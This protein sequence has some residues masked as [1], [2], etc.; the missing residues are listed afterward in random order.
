[1]PDPR[2][3]DPFKL[4]CDAECTHCGRKVKLLLESSMGPKP[5]DTIYKDPTNP[6]FGRCPQCKRLKLVITSVPTTTVQ[7]SV[8][9]FWKLP[10]DE[11]D[12]SDTETDS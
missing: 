5:G 3:V 10:V 11:P 7:Q 2:Y 12:S 6:N 1:M 9:G 4:A 8:T